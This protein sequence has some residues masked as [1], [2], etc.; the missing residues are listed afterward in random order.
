[1]YKRKSQMTISN[2]SLFRKFLYFPN[3]DG[4]KIKSD[5]LTKCGWSQVTPDKV[6]AAGYLPHYPYSEGRARLNACELL[7][8]VQ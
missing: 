3:K 5:G 7:L 4:E 2:Q 1:M 6:S 8:S